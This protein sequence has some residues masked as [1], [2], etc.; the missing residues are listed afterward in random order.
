MPRSDNAAILREAAQRRSRDARERAEKTITA[1][2]RSRDPVTVAGLARA[3]GVSRAWLYTQPDLVQ[4]I[5]TMKNGA[6]SPVRTGRQPASS[7]S[8]HQRLDAA[9]HRIKQLRADNRELTHRLETA[10][11]EIRRL[12]ISL[13]NSTA[14]G[15]REG[16]A[17]PGSPR[18]HAQ[19]GGP[20]GS[21][22][23]APDPAR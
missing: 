3:A 17:R 10:H 16:H 22:N 4:A 9:Q 14:S 1:A 15:A 6:A 21:N 12:R 11:G 5:Q 13:P 23:R 20:L 18:D 19:P 2:Q 8:L 7:D